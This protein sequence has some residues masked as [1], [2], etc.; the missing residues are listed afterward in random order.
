MNH[1]AVTHLPFP[2]FLDGGLRCDYE[3]LR[4]NNKTNW[5]T[6]VSDPHTGSHPKIS[7][8]VNWEGFSP[9]VMLSLWLTCSVCFCFCSRTLKCCV[10]SLLK[11]R[12]VS[13]MWNHLLAWRNLRKYERL[14]FVS[15]GVQ[16]VL[17]YTSVA[18]LMGIAN[19]VD[20]GCDGSEGRK[21]SDLKHLVAEVCKPE[22]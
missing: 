17:S 11:L 2:Y 10:N 5:P 21:I 7:T 16:P 4:K 22:S 14:Q 9:E 8:L 15:L 13:C 12:P 18:F 1:R 6:T 3:G 19:C 20:G